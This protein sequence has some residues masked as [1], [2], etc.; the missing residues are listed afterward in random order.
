MGPKLVAAEAG[1]V[2]RKAMRKQ[3]EKGA[4]R[5]L[6]IAIIWPLSGGAAA[7]KSRKIAIIWPKSGDGGARKC[8]KTVSIWQISAKKAERA[9]NLFHSL[10]YITS[11]YSGP[12]PLAP[13]PK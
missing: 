4:E 11:Y 2:I 13:S 5:F 10:L 6:K 7:P 12:Q 9:S 3:V 8:L 1:M